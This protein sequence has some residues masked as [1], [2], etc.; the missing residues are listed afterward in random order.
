MS[1]PA[2]SRSGRDV[3]TGTLSD[4]LPKLTAAAVQAAPVFMDRDATVEKAC[5][6][7]DEASRAGAKLIVF[8]ETWIPTYPWW[9]SSP[10]VFSG[11][12]FSELWRNAIEVPSPPTARLG[13]AAAR[14]GAYVA[15]GINERDSA[16]RGTL[17]NS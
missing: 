9:H 13:A 15:I 6:L 10:H 12:H 2:H 8:P 17:Y 1:L 4:S 7:I 3:G 16:S 5:A 11:H 14:A